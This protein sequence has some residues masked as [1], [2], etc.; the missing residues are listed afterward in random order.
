M[1]IT[2]P[3]TQSDI[4]RFWSHVNRSAGPDAC[5]DWQR[6]R[7]EHGYGMFKLNGRAV[8]T[9]R[10]AAYITYGA[11]PDGYEVHHKCTNRACV[12]PKHLEPLSSADHLNLNPLTITQRARTL[13]QRCDSPLRRDTDQRRCRKCQ[14]ERR[15]KLTQKRR[16]AME[17]TA[18]VEREEE[19]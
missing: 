6:Y 5:W 12:N 14:S 7:D 2:T 13:C 9:H 17:Q 3:P 10:F 16:A 15:R 4:D 19:V 18:R 11:I 8:R 1:P